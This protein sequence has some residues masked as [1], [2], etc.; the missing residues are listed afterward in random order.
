MK[1][2]IAKLLTVVALIAGAVGAAPSAASANLAGDA[3]NHLRYGGSQSVAAQFS[4]A[5]W[6]AFTWYWVQ[7]GSNTPVGFAVNT[8]YAS[9]DGKVGTCNATWY[10]RH[11]GDGANN[12]CPFYEYRT[13][14]GY[15]YSR[16]D[17]PCHG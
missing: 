7:V 17:G 15:V 1:T 12:Y 9:P 13:N 11:N 3:C 16:F 4:D 8:S 2:R 5:R 14:T 10:M 6:G